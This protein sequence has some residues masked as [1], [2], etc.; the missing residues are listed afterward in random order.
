LYYVTRKT[1]DKILERWANIATLVALL[2]AVIAFIFPSIQEAKSMS[3]THSVFANQGWSDTGIDVEK[4]DV[5][6]IEYK[7]GYWTYLPGKSTL[8]DGN[9]DIYYI[10]TE[11]ISESQCIEQIPGRPKGSLIARVGTSDPVYIGNYN[12][13]SSPVSGKLLLSINDSHLISDYSDNEGSLTVK[14][15]V[16]R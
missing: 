13:F 9:G 6:T 16:E 2:A 4:G 12:I 10:C 3:L 5:I 11:T 15:T 14:I 7:G 8:V 1:E